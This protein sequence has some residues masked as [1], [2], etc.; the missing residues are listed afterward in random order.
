MSARGCIALFLTTFTLVGRPLGWV[1]VVVVVYDR[2]ELEVRPD[3][4]CGLR[5][6]WHPIRN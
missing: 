5:R 6:C 3:V 1:V 2:V 4:G